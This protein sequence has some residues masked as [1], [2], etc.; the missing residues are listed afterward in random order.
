MDSPLFFTHDVREVEAG[1]LRK[2]SMLRY[3]Y[4]PL[5]TFQ[6]GTATEAKRT[7]GRRF[8]R[9]LG[10]QPLSS[11]IE[12]RLRLNMPIPTALKIEDELMAFSR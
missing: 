4:A 1:F 8:Y 5:N 12:V 7:T 2:L 6:R 9:I 3:M 11:S 10:V